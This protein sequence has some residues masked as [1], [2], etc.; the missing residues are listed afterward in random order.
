MGERQLDDL[1]E[2]CWLVFAF[3]IGAFACGLLID[4][5][6]VHFLGKAFYGLALVG[7]SFLLVA[8]AF[9]PYRLAS[10]CLAAVACGLQNAMCTSHFG[11][12]VRTT[13]VTGTVTDIGSTLGRMA[14]IYLRKGCRRSRLNVVERAEVGVDARK[15]L[16]LLPMWC[17]FLIGCIAGAFVEN[18]C[19]QVS[20]LVPAVFTFITGSCYMLFRQTLKDYAKS[21]EEERLSSDIQEAHDALEHFR[22]TLGTV[23]STITSRSGSSAYSTEQDLVA[24]VDQHLEQM[25]EVLHNVEAEMQVLG[26]S[27]QK[28]DPEQV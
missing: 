12:V 17:C 8:A 22:E 15:L 11:A 5:N 25:L 24:D 21:L 19:R 27:Q 13:H 10:A 7:N 9:V 18:E 4:K 3:L 20:F 16:V 28:H 6:T 1:G 2:S 14:M 23:Q 26:M